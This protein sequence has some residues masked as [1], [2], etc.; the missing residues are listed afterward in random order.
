[1]LERTFN[2]MNERENLYMIYRKRCSELKKVNFSN[3]SL[4]EFCNFKDLMNEKQFKIVMNEK[5]RRKNKRY[6][7]NK[8]YE[9]LYKIAQNLNSENKKIVFG[10]CTLDDK[11]LNQTEDSYI[12]KINDWLKSHFIYAIVNKDFG[13]ETEREHYHFIGLTTEDMEY[14]GIISK[15]RN[16]IYNLIKK[17]YKIGFEPD[18]CIIDNKANDMSKLIK[19]LVKENNHC[20]KKRGRIRIIKNTLGKTIIFINALELS[21]SEKRL[22]KQY[23]KSQLK[24]ILNS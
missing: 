9:L 5:Q 16:K 19:Y 24:R 1:M 10:T 3:E 22:K 7:V 2:S 14:T 20:M 23:T 21:K 13:S 6:R 18:L 8:K 17:D 11:N 4:N 15:K 12:G